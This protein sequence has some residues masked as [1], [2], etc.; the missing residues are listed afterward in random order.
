ML[1]IL[2][3][4]ISMNRSV[5]AKFMNMCM[6][7]DGSKIL[8]I[9]RTSD[10]WT[11]IA[12]PG[13]HVEN[14]EAF[15]ESVI[16]EVYEETGLTIENPV[17]C[18]IKEWQNDDLSRDVVL[19]YK[20]DKFSGELV[21]SNEGDVFWINRDDINNYKLAKDFDELLRVFEDDSLSEFYYKRMQ[22]GWEKRIY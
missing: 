12:F 14:G 16:R 20:T 19:L 1:I 15:A 10:K 18:G 2:Q 9:D 17:L 13:G 7:Y 3:G 8:V 4:R 5:A 11:G 6:I 22:N 21:S